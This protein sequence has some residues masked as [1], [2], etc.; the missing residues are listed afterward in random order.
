MALVQVSFLGRVPQGQ[1]GYVR[2]RYRFADGE[3]VEAAFFGLALAGRLKPQRLAILGTAGSMW[4]T[5]LD[6]AEACGREAAIR[7]RLEA[8][9]RADRTPQ[10]DLDVAALMLGERLGYEVRLVRI[11]YGRSQD[12]QTEILERI[13]EQVS[14][15]D[16]VA[17]DVTHGLR[18]LPM[19]GLVSAVLV[20]SVRGA[21][22]RGVYYGALDMRV[23][24][25][26][27]V[28]EL[29]GLLAISDWARAVA[30][31]EGG[32]DYGA[33]AHELAGAGLPEDLVVALRKAS[34][35]EQVCRFGQAVNQLN[36]ARSV[37]KHGLP[38]PARLLTV[39][40][41]RVLDRVKATTPGQRQYLLA[42]AAWERGDLV[43]AVTLL[44]EAVI[45]A[46]GGPW[47]NP[48]DIEEREAIKKAIR[49]GMLGPA[50][51]REPFRRLTELRNLLVHGRGRPKDPEIQVWLD[52]P[53]ALRAGIESI[54]ARLE[55]LIVT[56]EPALKVP[57]AG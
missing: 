10:E 25:A 7:R 15:G 26:A 29:S 43:R 35:Y 12:E 31:F 46:L 54:F 21:R 17:L 4:H 48:D 1:D 6:L 41:Q 11:P 36:Q 47:A 16:E 19:L 22:V 30:R 49:E 39:P 50:E 28:L 24:D 45:T 9:G 42:R 2:A 13:A 3:Q 33:L 27:P 44:Q 51:I 56:R 20:G 5:L 37:L 53:E 34:F 38:G 18:H 55:P 57:P 8:E 52:N 14:Q 32:G 40:L 23:D